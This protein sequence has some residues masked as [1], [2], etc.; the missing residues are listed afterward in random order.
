MWERDEA[1][2]F[3]S[4]SG[5]D[6]PGPVFSPALFYVGD[7][8]EQFERNTRNAPE[9][10]LSAIARI[11]LPVSERCLT[12]LLAVPEKR[13]IQVQQVPDKSN[14]REPLLFTDGTDLVPEPFPVQ[15]NDL[16]YEGNTLGI[17][18]V[19]RVGGDGEGMR[20]P[21]AA[22][23]A[24]QRDDK[25]DPVRAT[26]NNCWSHSPLLSWRTWN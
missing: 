26:D 19:M 7:G 8:T 25:D 22:H 1:A 16:E 11:T 14:D 21:G 4:P 15:S 10:N 24:G 9:S 20:E 6:G 23:A 13:L 2:A 12:N 3:S 17:E 5:D 18:T